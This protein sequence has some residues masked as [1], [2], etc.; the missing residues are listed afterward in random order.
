MSF[1]YTASGD[2]HDSWAGRADAATFTYTSSGDDHAGA[3]QEGNRA[4]IQ[5]KTCY[6]AHTKQ[7]QH[8]VTITFG[9]PNRVTLY[10]E[11]YFR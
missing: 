11:P 5:Q 6:G 8:G 9:G 7:S 2:E 4:G 1:T 10:S 3:E